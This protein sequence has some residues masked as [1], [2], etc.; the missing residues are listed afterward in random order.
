MN[1]NAMP[2]L[3]LGSICVVVALLLSV[4]NMITAPA[5]AENQAAAANAALLDVLPGGS[6]FKEIDLSTAEYP[7]IVTKGWSADGGS[8]FQISTT[9]KSSGFVIMCGVDAEGKLVGTKVIAN[10]E[11]PSYAE[12]V[13]PNVEGTDG[14]Y[15]GMDVSDFEAYLVSG[16]TLT[17]RAFSEAVKAALQSA[18]IAAGGEVDTRDPEQILQDNCNAAL[19]TE[20]KVF[21]KWFATEIITGVDAIYENADAGRV[22]VIGESFIGVTVDGTLVEF[23]EM[24]SDDAAAATAA[25]ALI[26]ASTTTDVQIP[27]G[28][29]DEI[30]SIKKTAS[31]NYIIEAYG[32]GYGVNGGNKYHPASGEPIIV[33]ISISADGA[34]IDSFTV[35]EEETPDIGG[36]L[37]DDPAFYE[38]YE[39]KTSENYSDVENKA[40]ATLTSKGYKD[41]LKNAFGVIEMIEGENE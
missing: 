39:G 13:F 15:S 34:I 6:N 1:K 24:S 37:L 36:A 35:E 30:V 40:G 4:V 11:T 38:P 21:T 10:E 27:A 12:K 14:V 20:D 23:P 33:K 3:V 8:V 41:A 19:G 9:G 32:D 2:S 5:I 29:G 16:A 22:Y 31:G 26:N 7:S 18:V 17:S 25:D 28:A